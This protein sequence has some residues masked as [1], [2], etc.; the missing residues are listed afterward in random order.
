M[1]RIRAQDQWED[2]QAEVAST[3]WKTIKIKELVM[4]HQLEKDT[5]LSDW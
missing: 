2:L 3:I 1:A 5:E 4:D